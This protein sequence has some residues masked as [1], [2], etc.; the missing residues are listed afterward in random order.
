M[1]HLLHH[2]IFPPLVFFHSFIKQIFPLVLSNKLIKIMSLKSSMVRFSLVKQKNRLLA[3]HADSLNNILPFANSSNLTVV[4]LDPGLRW[5]LCIE[6]SKVSVVV[7]STENNKASKEVSCLLS[8]QELYFTE[9]ITGGKCVRKH[10]HQ[11]KQIS[12]FTAFI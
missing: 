3:N 9:K 2:L 1:V 8:F 12:R 7:I 10:L 6:I 4:V 11:L 5:R